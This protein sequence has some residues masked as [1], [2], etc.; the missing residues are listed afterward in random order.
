MQMNDNIRFSRQKFYV[1]VKYMSILVSF[2]ADSLK[3]GSSVNKN[4]VGSSPT[5]IFKNFAPGYYTIAMTSVDVPYVH[6]LKCNVYSNGASG[7]VVVNYSGP[8]P[9]IIEKRMYSVTAWRQLDGRFT[10]PPKPPTSRARFSLDHFVSKYNLAA[11]AGIA[12]LV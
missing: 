6:W 11:V 3:N 2:G 9:S 7:S 5:V 8:D 10:P 1:A 12:F 4:S